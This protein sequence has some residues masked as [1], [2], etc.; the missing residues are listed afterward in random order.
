MFLLHQTSARQRNWWQVV[1]ERGSIGFVPSNY[2]E[3]LKVS[4]RPWKIDIFSIA[5]VELTSNCVAVGLISL[6][7]PSSLTFRLSRRFFWSSWRL[8]SRM[9]RKATSQTTNSSRICS[10]R[11]RIWRRLCL[12]RLNNCPRRPHLLERSAINRP[13]SATAR[14]NM[15][16]TTIRGKKSQRLKKSKRST[17]AASTSRPRSPCRLLLSM[18][19]NHRN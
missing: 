7:P 12:A 10:K 13:K 8:S 18:K 9:L 1:N 2:V 14:S 6:S 17:K 11:S 3:K 16:Q 5:Q 4:C 15:P 19:R